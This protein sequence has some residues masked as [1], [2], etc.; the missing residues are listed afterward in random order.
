M[1]QYGF[2]IAEH[3]PDRRWMVL[4]N[5]HRTMKLPDE[6]VFFAWAHK[7]GLRLAGLSSWIHANS[8]RRGRGDPRWEA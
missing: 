4:S 3:D 8:D 7:R 6:H 1:R 5:E 2:T